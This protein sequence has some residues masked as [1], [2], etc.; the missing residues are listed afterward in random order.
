MRKVCIDRQK[1]RVKK[2]GHTAGRQCPISKWIWPMPDK[3]PSSV[4]SWNNNNNSNLDK[5]IEDLW[6]MKKSM[7]K[8]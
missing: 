5:C 2:F 8:G 7:K 1:E 3:S 6:K 4:G